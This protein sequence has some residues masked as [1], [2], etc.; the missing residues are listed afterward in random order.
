M[1]QEVFMFY[2]N[3][4]ILHLVATFQKRHCL[5][6]HDQTVWRKLWNVDYHHNIAESSA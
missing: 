6:H 1:Q 5:E 2:K 4:N 3:V